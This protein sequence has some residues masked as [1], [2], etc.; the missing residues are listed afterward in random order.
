MK[1]RMSRQLYDHTLLVTKPSTD[2][3]ILL[4]TIR[5]DSGASDTFQPHTI[6]KA[7]DSQHT[8]STSDVDSHISAHQQDN[9]SDDRSIS[10]LPKAK[11][12]IMPNSHVQSWMESSF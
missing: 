4:D 7:S 6:A 9:S 3:D 2:N 11:Y 12:M 1:H 5:T 10:P 8:S